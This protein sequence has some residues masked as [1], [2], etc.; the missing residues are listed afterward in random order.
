MPRLLSTCGIDTEMSTFS[1]APVLY[2]AVGMPKANTT[3][4]ALTVDRVIY[5]TIDAQATNKLAQ[6][7]K[8]P[9]NPPPLGK[10]SFV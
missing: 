3:G 4:P 10:C 8:V 6:K 9:T 5:T 1:Q 7:P 2:A